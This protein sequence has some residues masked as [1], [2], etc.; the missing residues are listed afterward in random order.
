[1]YLLDVAPSP[2]P[3]GTT[4]IRFLA[5]ADDDVLGTLDAKADDLLFLY[6]G[7]KEFIAG[8]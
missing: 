4:F 7:F 1:M 3:F 5:K 8:L 2:A 6:T